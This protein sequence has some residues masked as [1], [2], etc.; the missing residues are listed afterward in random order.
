MPSEHQRFWFE[1]MKITYW[2]DCDDESMFRVFHM[3]AEKYIQKTFSIARSSLVRPLLLA[4]EIW[5]QLQMYWASQ[6]FQ[7][8]SSMNKAN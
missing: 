4:N 2:W 7:Q 6:D 5:L 1:S 3:W 8:E